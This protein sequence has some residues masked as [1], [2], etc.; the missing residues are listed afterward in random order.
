VDIR[1]LR[2]FVAIVEEGSVSR[3]A[4]K[5][6]VVQPALSQRLADL[7]ADVGVQLL[8][9]GAQGTAPTPAGE[10]LYQRALVIIKQLDAARLAV[11]GYSGALTGPVHVGLLRT[12]ASAVTPHLFQRVQQQYPQVQLHIRIGYSAEL[13]ALIRAGRL[14]VGMHVFARGE[15]KRQSLPIYSEGL[16]AVGPSSLLPSS[17]PLRIHDLAGIPLLLSLAQPSY[18]LIVD[19]ASRA[20]VTLSILG[21]VEDNPA[22]LD[23]CQSGAALTIQPETVAAIEASKRGLAVALLAEPGLER[24]VGL[25]T[26]PDFQPTP[27]MVAVREILTSTLRDLFVASVER[28]RGSDQDQL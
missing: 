21:D 19:C 17:G 12:A 18:A 15:S 16:C 9:R 25:I 8:V 27:A 23:I 7:E 11:Q 26:S 6:H 14:D 10:D 22:L 1:Q 13:A 3:A 24:S 5:L 20:G 4:R 28:G 2:Y